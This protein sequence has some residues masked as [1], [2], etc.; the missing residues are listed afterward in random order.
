MSAAPDIPHELATSRVLLRFVIRTTILGIFAIVI[1]QGFAKTFASLLTLTGLYC[2]VAG[3]VKR[4]EPFGPALTNYDE[5]AA[6]AV[7]G[8]SV[9]SWIL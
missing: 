6:Y 8:A 1:A 2:V 4:E 5:A 3:A 7:V 9:A